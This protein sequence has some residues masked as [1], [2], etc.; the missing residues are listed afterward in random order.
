MTNMGQDPGPDVARLV[1]EPIRILYLRDTDKVCGPGKTILN[2]C[3]TADPQ[4]VKLVVAATE[5]REPG[6]NVLLQQV[7][8]TGVEA[9]PIGIGGFFDLKALWRLMRL[10]RK[11][12][13]DLLQTHDPQTRRL[14][15]VAAFLTGVTH[16]A[17]LH[18]WIQNTRKQKLSATLDRWLLR[19]S[20]RV[21]V[22]SR[23]MKDDI[24]ASGVA[25]EKIAIVHN[26]VVLTDYPSSYR[27]D[28]VRK[29][30]G[31][32]ADETVIAVIGRFS[33]EKGHGVFL[34]SARRI[35]EARPDVRFLLVGDGPL[36]DVIEK[37]IELLDL[38]KRF[39]LTGHR[40][41][42]QDVYSAI[43]ILAIPSFT[44]GLPNVLLEA[45]AFGKPVVSTNVGG[46]SEVLVDGV[47]GY[48]VEPGDFATLADRLT[49]LVLNRAAARVMGQQGRSTIEQRFSFEGRT[50]QLTRLYEGLVSGGRNRTIPG[51]R[52]TDRREM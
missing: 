49:K 47:N 11:H 50:A 39:V 19:R 34:D 36:R 4:R 26:A 23:L 21:I 13:I 24:V 29:E 51:P 35:V 30:Y 22:M 37:R 14:G 42:M 20:K 48:L 9:E 38:K 25:S 46:V 45:F 2:T 12:R 5:V 32:A 15:A 43:D 41:D 3:R 18:G 44:E 31:I 52:Q 27:S 7:A 1:N 33:A 16:V 17:S 40:T 8:R 10:I 28:K 6:G